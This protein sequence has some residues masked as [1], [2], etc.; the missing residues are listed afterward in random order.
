MFIFLRL[1]QYVKNNFSIFGENR[2]HK[3]EEGSFIK[4]LNQSKNCQ[5]KENKERQKIFTII[6]IEYAQESN[7]LVKR[8]L[9]EAAF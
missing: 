5:N 1:L 2:I 7:N 9:L 6:I 3:T 4:L 8:I